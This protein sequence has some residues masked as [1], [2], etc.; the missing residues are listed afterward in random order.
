MSDL[1]EPAFFVPELEYHPKDME[2]YLGLFKD[3]GSAEFVGES[4][5][6]YTKLPLFKGVPQR[7]HSFS[8]DARLI[9][10]MRDPIGRAISHYWHNTRSVRSE[11]KETRPMLEAIR[12]D[13]L[14]RAYSDYA[15]QIRPWIDLFGRDAVLPL[16]HEELTRHPESTLEH[17]FRWL[18]LSPVPGVSLERKNAR[19]E[20]VARPRGSGF[21][22]RLRHTRSWDAIA[23]FFPQGIKDLARGLAVE[24]K[25]T[26][27][28]DQSEAVVELLRP[29]AR[30]RIFAVSRLFEMDFS[31]WWDSAVE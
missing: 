20:G 4:S 23:P 1:K 2:W 15:M 10:L 18:G 26:E 29:W 30:E 12:D 9:Y 6:H 25:P 27:F 16:V 13:P 14:Y 21:L 17:V 19:P 8:P 11:F 5:T 24:V 28:E 22:H 31:T 7:V 3:A